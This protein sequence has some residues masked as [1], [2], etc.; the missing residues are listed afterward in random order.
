MHQFKAAILDN[1]SSLER[2]NFMKL[3]KTQL[4]Y[5]LRETSVS[6]F[7]ALINTP[8]LWRILSISSKRNCKLSQKV[9]LHLCYIASKT[10]ES[11]I[12]EMPSFSDNSCSVFAKS[13]GLCTI[14]I[15]QYILSNSCSDQLEKDDTD[16]SLSFSSLASLWYSKRLCLL[17]N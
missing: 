6:Y 9:L 2:K 12:L 17:D 3:K 13:S 7:F 1:Q 4:F 8:T 15:H 5:L 14:F 11:F 16:T 10:F